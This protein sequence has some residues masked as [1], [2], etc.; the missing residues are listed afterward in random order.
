MAAP[1]LPQLDFDRKAETLRAD[2]QR[3][4]TGAPSSEQASTSKEDDTATASQISLSR[5]MQNLQLAPQSITT[6]LPRNATSDASSSSSNNNNN[7]N[8]DNN[9]AA[10]TTPREPPKPRSV[11]D[12]D[13]KYILG[14]GSYSTVVYTVEK[15]TQRTFA[16]KILDKKHIVKEKKIKYVNVEKSVMSATRHPFILK[17]YY[18]LQDAQSL[19]FVLELAECG[20][21]LSYI[22]KYQ[23]FDEDT[24]RFYAAEIVTAIEYLHRKRFLHRDL[25]PENILLDK[26]MHIKLAD[27][28]SAKILEPQPNISTASGPPP[29]APPPTV[30]DGSSPA[31]AEHA[32]SDPSI[33]SRAGTPY[34]SHSDLSQSSTALS[35][36]QKLSPAKQS[37]GSLSSVSSSSAPPVAKPSR[38]FVGTAEY[39]SPEMLQDRPVTEASDVWA[40]GCIIY[41]LLAG[42]PPFKGSNDYQTFQKI[43]RLE[44]A[45]PDAFPELARDLV[46]R[47]L[48]SAPDQRITI[49]AIKQ[50]PFFSSVNF[51]WNE[52]WNQTAPKIAPFLPRMGTSEELRSEVITGVDR[53]TPDFDPLLPIL[54]QQSGRPP[55][56]TTPDPSANAAARAKLLAQQQLLKWAVFLHPDEL[57]LHMGSVSKRKGLFAKKRFLILTD[58]PRLVYIDEDKMVVKGEIPWSERLVPEFK[59]KRNFFVHTPGR[60]YYLEC[61]HDDAEE[62]VKHLAEMRKRVVAGEFPHLNKQDEFTSV[63][64]APGSPQSLASDTSNPAVSPALLPQQQ[65]QQQRPANL[66]P[67]PSSTAATTT[68]P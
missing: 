56:A 1:M 45:F 40:I 37:N 6:T 65:Q 39:V 26:N 49:P 43:I 29:T 16:T 35:A 51:N 61:S 19:Y 47:I 33:A 23:A 68:N 36:S 7:N 22:R 63:L 54:N 27:F 41:Q 55:V 46:S 13:F 60:T 20:E 14:E 4:D 50:H 62:W 21:L 64:L 31:I 3:R 32:A 67:F 11:A 15:S 53:P 10:P 57:I 58:A 28:G 17:L 2:E 34:A 42:R 38:S 8:N 25:K 66:T 48:V 30:N 18:T 9:G 44:Y 59:N 12:F 5:N 24:T 52:L